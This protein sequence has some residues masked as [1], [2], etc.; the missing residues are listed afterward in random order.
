MS[1]GRG[2][3]Q[4]HGLEAAEGLDTRFLC[5]EIFRKVEYFFVGNDVGE[6]FL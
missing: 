4:S 6:S 5:A 2:G 1:E 3:G